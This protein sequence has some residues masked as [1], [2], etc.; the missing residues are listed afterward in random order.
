M[1]LYNRTRLDNKALERVIYLAGKATRIGVRTSNVVV[2]VTTSKRSCSGRVQRSRGWKYYEGWL[3]NGKTEGY[4][5]SALDFVPTDKFVLT[6]GGYM[7]LRIPAKSN[8]AGDDPLAAAERF[9]SLAAHEWKHIADSQ[10]GKRFGE[11]NK[12]WA[13]R[14]HERRAIT[15]GKR[16]EKI[17]DERADVQEAILAL[18]INIEE[19]RK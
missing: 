8:W 11:Y 18:A 10:K 12:K 15:V 3:K 1:K 17:K 13:N 14:P 4:W 2:R 9:F 7:F 6:D 19:L 16:A 5:S